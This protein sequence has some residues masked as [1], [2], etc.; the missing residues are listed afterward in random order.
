MQLLR[1]KTE[2]IAALVQLGLGS[3]VAFVQFATS[4]RW[5]FAVIFGLVLPIVVLLDWQAQQGRGEQAARAA[6]HTLFFFS[7]ALFGAGL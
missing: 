4:G 6:N 3:C 2:A 7:F 1:R 5:I